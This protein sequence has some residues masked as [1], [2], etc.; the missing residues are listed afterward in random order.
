[1]KGTLEAQG[2][3]LKIIILSMLACIVWVIFELVRAIFARPKKTIFWVLTPI[4]AVKQF[5][6]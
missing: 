3:S 4:R 1:M 2:F 6:W 5:L